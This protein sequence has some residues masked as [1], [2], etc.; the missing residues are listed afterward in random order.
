MQRK[1]V[2]ALACRAGGSRL[3]GKPV[4]NL[5]PK[6]GITILDHLVELLR[7]YGQIDEIVLG[8]SEGDENRIFLEAAE[9]LGIGAI[10]GDQKD[11]LQRLI[12][13]A[14]AVDATDV[15]RITTECPFPETSVLP[16][17]WDRHLREGNDVTVTDGVPEG[18]HFEIYTLDALRQSHAKGGEDERSERC[19]LY[20]RRHLE[21]FKVERLDIPESWK[22][23]DL[24]LTVDYPEDLVLCR[25]IY[26]ALKQPGSP[27]IALGSII[28]W[29]DAHPEEHA[30]VE[31]YVVPKAIWQPAG[32]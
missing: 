15:F 4:Q 17:A 31:P 30:L 22:R 12:Q 11:V 18:T 27:Y 10:V 19:S 20:V 29:L 13:C 3:Y 7:G 24:R 5:D 2:A 21:D 1:L 23:L 14:E 28:E 25:R 8:I 32:V 6:A 9:R 16:L 26:A